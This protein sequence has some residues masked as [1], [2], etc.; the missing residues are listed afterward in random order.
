M[1]YKCILQVVLSQGTIKKGAI[2][3]IKEVVG[4]IIAFGYVI[5]LHDKEELRIPLD[6]FKFCFKKQHK[7]KK[8][9]KLLPNFSKFIK[10]YFFILP[11][12]SK[13]FRGGYAKDTVFISGLS[14]PAP[15][16]F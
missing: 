1:K 3:K 14:Y 13:N 15:L 10:S 2:I 16:C 6:V 8:L 11:I 12:T 7:G 9:G 4:C 5:G